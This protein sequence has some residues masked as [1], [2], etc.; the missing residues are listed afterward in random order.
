MAVGPGLASISMFVDEGNPWNIVNAVVG[1][2]IAW[3]VAFIASFLLWRDSDSAT[4]R[5]L[6][7]SGDA[8]AL[9][10]DGAQTAPAR[11][12][13]TLVAPMSGRVVGLDQVDDAVFSSGSLGDGFAL[14]PTDGRVLA[15]VSGEIISLLPSLHAI[16]IRTDD[17]AEVLVHVGLDT[18]TLAGTHFTAHAAQGDRVAAGDLLVTVDLDAVRAAGYDLTTPVV[19]IN[20]DAWNVAVDASGEVVAGEPVVTARPAKE[21]ADVAS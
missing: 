8:D 2:A 17:G 18:V 1:A 21:G 16:G 4:L 10:A 5:V 11:S 12:D 20:S 3:V 19:V 7:E 13:V 14:L 9:G 6:A 15:P